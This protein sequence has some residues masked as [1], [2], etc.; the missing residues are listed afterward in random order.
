MKNEKYLDMC[1]A[2][3]IG[4]NISNLNSWLKTDEKTALSYAHHGLGATLRNNLGLWHGSDI[5]EWFNSIGIYH[6]DDMSSIILTSFHRKLNKK[7]I[8]L[9]QQV[10]YYRNYWEKKDP[11]VNKGKI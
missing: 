9:E 1:F 4:L 5:K 8:N 10:Q 2:Y 11:S 7:F 6:P 3:L